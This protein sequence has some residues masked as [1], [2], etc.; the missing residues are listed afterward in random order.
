MAVVTG[1]LDVQDP[2]FDRSDAYDDAA[3]EFLGQVS[4]MA[5]MPFQVAA[6]SA[7]AFDPLEPVIV[8]LYLLGAALLV[9]RS[10]TDAT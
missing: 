8:R 10:R 1:R 7:A 4:Y 5:P 2:M 9:R 6:E 3:A